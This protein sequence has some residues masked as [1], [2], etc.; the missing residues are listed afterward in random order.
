M[1]VFPNPST[2]WP[3][4]VSGNPKGRPKG[5]SYAAIKAQFAQAVD[6]NPALAHL[7]ALQFVQMLLKGDVRPA[8]LLLEYEASQQRAR[9][10]RRRRRR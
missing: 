2:R 9:E 8:R 10:R 7:M 1:G 5:R 4:G 3:P 6:S